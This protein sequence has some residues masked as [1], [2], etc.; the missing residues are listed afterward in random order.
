MSLDEFF[1]DF[2][3]RRYGKLTIG[4][5]EDMIKSLKFEKVEE[6]QVRELFKSINLKKN[7]R[8]S[9]RE[10]ELAYDAQSILTL[11]P[12]IKGFK[13]TLLERLKSK[14]QTILLLMREFD[15]DGDDQ[16][17]EKEFLSLV[18]ALKVPKLETDSDKKF[19]FDTCNQDQD[20]KISEFELREFLNGG[21]I[22]DVVN[23]VEKIKMC[24][25]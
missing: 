20:K 18:E 5:F 16:L 21:K 15:K 12:F 8:L 24:L 9:F 25:R 2:D 22:I 1:N 17:D 3:M 19:L 14:H 7:Y 6:E 11:F 4:N 10:L 23:Y 13:V